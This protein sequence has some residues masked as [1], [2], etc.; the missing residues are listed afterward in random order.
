[1][2]LKTIANIVQASEHRADKPKDPFS[3]KGRVGALKTRRYTITSQQEQ[4][5]YRVARTVVSLDFGRSGIRAVQV[6]VNKGKGTVTKTGHVP[7]PAGAV[8]N[9]EI[10]DKETVVEALKEL[11]SKSKF[12]TKDVV[13][14]VGNQ[15]S[16][17]RPVE[18]EWLP[19]AEFKQSLPYRLG[20]EQL[21]VDVETLNLDYHTLAE[22]EKK[23]LKEG[24]SGES[25]EDYTSQWMSRILFVG[26]SKESLDLMAE[27]VIEAGLQPIKAE[28]ASFALI[29]SVRP[30]HAENTAEV[31]IDIGADLTTT[32]IHQSGQP[33]FVRM[34]T[35]QGGAYITSR[36]QD[37]M[38][39]TEAD[40][41]ATKRELGL[42]AIHN[43][44]TGKVQDVF[45]GQREEEIQAKKDH[46]AQKVINETVS[47]FIEEIRTSID[48][49]L[50][51]SDDI[52]SISR[53]VL[54]GGTGTMVGLAE[55]LSYELRTTV[56]YNDP[57]QGQKVALPEGVTQDQFNVAV[58]TALGVS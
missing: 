29:R 22:Y 54:S 55:R 47:G 46:P 7:L 56:E 44:N 34:V 35:G 48:F 57:F 5:G 32:V 52:E 28:L 6:S 45:G 19:E 16:T 50:G 43:V 13:F 41:E 53:V 15:S 24:A 49:F 36:I 20:D 14:A 51:H 58:G 1:M 38:S 12:K 8:S 11:W 23:T 30:E 2:P 17:V 10:S 39:W 40:A 26:V 37:K 42:D 18:L 33:K 9:G 4:V 25:E 27:T 21:A 3:R 31:V